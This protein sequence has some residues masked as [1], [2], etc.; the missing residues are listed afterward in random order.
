[1]D[2][3]GPHVGGLNL[4]YE[5]FRKYSWV[6][7]DY[8]DNTTFSFPINNFLKIIE[9]FLLLNFQDYCHE[10]MQHIFKAIFKT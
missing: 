6:R 2:P 9:E 4:I 1:M 5:I 7:P 3:T 10:I 8:L